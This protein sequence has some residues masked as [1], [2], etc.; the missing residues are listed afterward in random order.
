MY[1][2]DKNSD[3]V[4]LGLNFMVNVKVIRLVELEDKTVVLS[5]LNA[6]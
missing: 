4:N 1:I 6:P 2:V 3:K 5:K